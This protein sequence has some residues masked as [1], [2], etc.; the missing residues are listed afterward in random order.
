MVSASYD[1]ATLEFA[2]TLDPRGPGLATDISELG[3][4]A[5]TL[6][7]EVVPFYFRLVSEGVVDQFP[8]GTDVR[9]LFDATIA[10]PLTGE[11]SSGAEAAY[12]DRVDPAAMDLAV[13]NGF[14]TQISALNGQVAAPGQTS[15]SDVTLESVSWDFVRFKVQFNL[16]VG[17]GTPDL[18]A[19][20]PGLDFL[21]LPFRF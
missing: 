17:I 21:R 19:P 18:S 9:I 14:A 16:A 3:S 10:D 4:G 15:A 7:V 11:P 8:M 1:A 2:L 12:S 5:G 20:R 6:Q 13:K